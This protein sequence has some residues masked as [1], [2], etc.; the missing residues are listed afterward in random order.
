M[1]T[2]TLRSM[3][4]VLVAL[5][6]L[7]ANAY[8]VCIDGIY[9]NLVDEDETA[10]VISGKD[11][12]E[13]EIVIPESVEMYGVTYFV[14]SIRKGAFY[15]CRGLISVTIP[16]GVIS[17][18]DNAFEG[19]S[20][21]TSVTIPNSVT[22]IGDWAFGACHALTSVTIPNSVILI[23]DNAF[24]DCHG[25]TSVTIS[26][27][28]TSIGEG[29]FNSC[30]GLTSVT[31]PNSVTSIGD[32]AF[33]GCGGLT[34]VS[35]PNSV[36]SIG[37]GAF[38][39]CSGLT[40]VTIPNSVTSIGD[41]AFHFCHGL[42][43][44]SIPNSVT[45][46]G[47][48]AFYEC[49]ELTSLIIPGSVTSIGEDAFYGCYLVHFV[50]MSSLTSSNNWGATLCD[51]ETEDGL[52]IAD[53]ILAKCRK[54]ATSVTI[55]NGVTSIGEAA[56][57]GCSGLTSVTIPNSVTSIGDRAFWFCG[58]LTSVSIPNSVTSIGEEAFSSCD[59]LAFVTIPERVTLIRK[60]AFGGCY[61]MSDNFVNKSSLTSPSNWG[62]T[63][64]YE[65]TEDGLLIDDN[66]VVKCR[67]WATSVT[68]PN[69]VTSIGDYAFWLC[70]GLTSVSIPNSVTSIGD[71]SFGC[72]SELT[73]V[74][75][76]AESVPNSYRYYIFGGTPLENATL[77][78]PAASIS[79]YKT[80]DQWR[81]FGT[82]VAISEIAPM[83]EDVEVGFEESITEDTDLTSTVVDNVY[84]TIDV[85]ENDGYDTEEKCI[86]L[87]ST[88]T[89]E[90]FE[91]IADKDV[92]DEAVKENFNGL[93]FEVPAGKGTIC[94]NVQTK[95]SRTLNVKIG[96]AEAQTFVQPER[97]DVEIPC[98]TTEN[99]YVY[100][101]GAATAAGAQRRVSG[102]ETENGVLIYGI[103][104]E[105]DDSLDINAIAADNNGTYQIYTI[106]GRLVSTLQKGVNIIR[107][108]DGTTK[109]VYV[110]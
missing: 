21:L 87:A 47:G 105:T 109:S 62:A 27:N 78:V 52:L 30:S 63:L 24:N 39:Y 77:H 92:L 89:E 64:C 93:I 7:N 103:K 19:C 66:T 18:G 90:Q 50:N 110:K 69:G 97:G 38:A 49:S 6:S 91:V 60:N 4:A 53:N 68:I 43:S 98:S 46:I 75:C 3:M 37:G 13:V 65:E 104:W 72:C 31:I 15:D 74:Y 96:D 71:N 8:H 95:G 12:H 14:T 101:Y 22:S 25:L 10:E 51:E 29:A 54:W 88:V 9:Y 80:A 42:T 82:I 5:F 33:S 34:S 17:I 106:D 100:I 41:G 57:G 81:D 108:F 32:C 85:E 1:K 11:K 20:E 70:G 55:P 79:A 107:Y 36:T 56:F 23:G 59:G 83:E 44:V 28:L 2:F 99:T 84:V 45:S 40:S 102:K 86:V 61:F 94:I 58:G 67:K 35:I 73:D 76:Y 16:D 26:N 48:G